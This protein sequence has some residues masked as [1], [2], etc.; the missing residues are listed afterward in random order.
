[1][2]RKIE[3]KINLKELQDMIRVKNLVNDNDSD[4][5]IEIPDVPLEL[6]E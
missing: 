3:D 5:E 4:P 6:E 1:M 2:V